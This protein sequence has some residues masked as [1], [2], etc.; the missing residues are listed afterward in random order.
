MNSYGLE[1]HH[2]GLAV[3]SPEAAFRYLSDLG[4]RAGSSCYDPLQ[5]VNLAMRHH[6]RMPDVEVIWPGT[7][8]SPIDR[9][10]KKSDSMIY[11][12]CYT[13]KN[14][15]ASLVALESAGLEV[16][17]LG[18]AQ[19]ALLFD[20]IEVSFYNITGVGIIEIIAG[21]PESRT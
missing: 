10:L 2:F 5:K 4:Y 19:P 18:I 1:F 9:M 16:L 15:E 8:A 7:E 17:P 20:G 12:L 3:R 13:S 14:V 6:D 11:H 21:A